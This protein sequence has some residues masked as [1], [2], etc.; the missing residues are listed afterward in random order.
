[1]ISPDKSDMKAK[2][3]EATLLDYLLIFKLSV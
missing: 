3:K 1:M 2:E